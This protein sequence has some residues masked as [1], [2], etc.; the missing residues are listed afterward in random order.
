VDGTGADILSLAVASGDRLTVGYTLTALSL[1]QEANSATPL[2]AAV[3]FGHK[4]LLT[5]LL[6]MF[7]PN[8]PLPHT[9]T[10]LYDHITLHVCHLTLSLLMPYIYMELLVKP[11]I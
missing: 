11:E 5:I 6:D 1:D 10:V 2:A 3:M 9:G 4:H 8:D 7:K